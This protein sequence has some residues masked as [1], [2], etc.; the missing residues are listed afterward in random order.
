ML[1][2]ESLLQVLHFTDYRTLV[3][4]KLTSRHFLRLIVKFTEELARRRSFRVCFYTTGITYIEATT[5][6]R[7]MSIPCKPSLVAAC[8]EVA[9]VIGPHAVAKLTFSAAAYTWD[10]PDV[11]AIFEAAP[12]LKFAEEVE[13]STYNGVRICSEAFMHNFSGTRVL[14]LWFNYDTFCQ[15]NWAFLRRE[16]AR[17]LRRIKFIRISAWTECM[18][19]SVEELVRECAALPRLLGGEPLELDLSSNDYSGEFG[20]RIIEVST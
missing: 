10:V 9:R 5:N 15:F 17:E 4:A 3:L 20:K 19:R 12:P 8:R 18:D 16:S 1:P 14:D 2:N 13:I 7:R 11:N 6:A